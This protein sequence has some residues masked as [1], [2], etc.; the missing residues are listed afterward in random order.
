MS[1]IENGTAWLVRVQL[2]CFAHYTPCHNIYPFQSSQ[3]YPRQGMA[4]LIRA[5]TS[6][7]CSERLR[8]ARKSATRVMALQVR[9]FVVLYRSSH[10]NA[11]PVAP[12][13]PLAVAPTLPALPVGP[14]YTSC[15]SSVPL[16]FCSGQPL[17]LF[18]V[19]PLAIGVIG[20][21]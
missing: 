7:T 10:C 16:H 13:S 19:T 17:Y 6:T 2:V 5:S 11:F 15:A 21:I 4:Y 12:V 8:W 20:H 14:I 3:E 18:M 1:Y 9:A